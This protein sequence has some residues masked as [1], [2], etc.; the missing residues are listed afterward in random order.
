MTA[1]TLTKDAPIAAVEKSALSIIDYSLAYK[2]AN[3]LIPA[4]QNID[5]TIPKG[6]TVGLVGESGSGKSSMAW[7]IMRYLPSNAVETGGAIRLAG[8]ELLDYT[9]YQMMDIR[10]RRMSMVFQDPSTSLNP[11]IKLGEQIAEVLMRHRGLTKAQAWAEA[12][13]ALGR[14]GIT[15]PKEMLQRFPHEASGG[16]KQRVVIATAFACEPELII[17]DEPT[18]ALDILTARQILDL[19]N[20][21]REET[22]VSALYISHD[23]GLVSRV[24]DRV[25]VIH[26]GIIVESGSVQEVFRR[27]KADYTRQLIGAVPDPDRWV[28]VDAPGE[29]KTLLRIDKVGVRYGAPTK[30]QAMFWP[31]DAET[32]G[33]WGAK[34]ISIDVRK[35]ELLGVVGESGSGKSTIAK[36]LAGLQDFEGKLDF[37]GKAITSRNAIDRAYRRRVQIVFQHPDA[38]LNPRHRIGTIIA[39]PLKLYG[40]VPKHEIKARVAELLEMVR[41][42]ASYADRLPHQLSGGEKQRVAIARAFAA[43]PELVICDEVTAALDVSVQ[44]AVAELLVKLQRNTGAA[45]VF[46]THDLNLI[47]QLAHRIAVMHH[48][49]LVDFFDRVDAR[50]VDRDPYAK[51]LLDAVPVHA[52]E[53]E[54]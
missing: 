27:P 47:R 12:E 17:F 28:G 49:K 36:V 16:E 54:A 33:F 25:S 21:L 42:P 20:Q 31:T 52:G 4:L 5:L 37:D 13:A 39:R 41:L 9:P 50:S 15:R 53:P 44:A 6:K 30:L 40:I 2:T 26:K 34:D 48:G 14:T 51:A 19:F 45:C 18:T 10:G 23:L 43:E 1:Q 29:P 35:G 8:E 7:S 46:I 32:V 38:S 24:V 22:N 11:T 3:G